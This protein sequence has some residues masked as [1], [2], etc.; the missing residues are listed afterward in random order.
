MKKLTLFAVIFFLIILSV[1]WNEDVWTNSI[2]KIST[3][4]SHI[5]ENY[6]KDMDPEELA[7]SSVRGMLQTLDPHSNFLDMR[8]M[9]RLTEDYRA[10]Y[11][12][13][14]KGDVL[15]SASG[16]I[17]RRVVYDGEPAYFQ[18]S[19]IVWVANDE[20]N[21]TNAYLYEFYGA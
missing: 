5:E 21:I 10:K 15:I 6:Y 8:S 7:Y 12:F 18:D 20:T 16:T 17:G 4:I 11:S 9:S 19:N 3:I 1:A 13:P 14:R 2:D